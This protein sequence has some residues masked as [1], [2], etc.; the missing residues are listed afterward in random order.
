MK[1]TI[2]FL[3][4]TAALSAAQDAKSPLAQNLT[5]A[6]TCSV[7]INE[8]IPGLSGFPGAMSFFV[9]G[10][11]IGQ[12]SGDGAAAIQHG[13]WVRTGD[14]TFRSSWAGFAQDDKLRYQGPTKV[15]YNFRLGADLLTLNGVYRV[16][17][18]DTKG[19]KTFGFTG[20]ASCSR[21]QLDDFD[22]QP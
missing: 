18:F 11:V 6:W 8:S 15:V 2:L 21:V 17:F 16:D 5:G 22:Q 19:N 12:A 10:N 3:I 4:L 14:G 13:I 20:K 7:T 1:H 9:D